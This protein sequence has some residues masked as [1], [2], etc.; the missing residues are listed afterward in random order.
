MKRWNLSFSMNRNIHTRV[1]TKP[2]CFLFFDYS[3]G[4]SFPKSE[5]IKKIFNKEKKNGPKNNR[6]F[7]VART[8]NVFALEETYF[9]V[10]H[11][12]CIQQTQRT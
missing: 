8:T 2:F 11:L 6:T 5:K 1:H 4:T 9:S 7:T 10:P 3:D 12:Q